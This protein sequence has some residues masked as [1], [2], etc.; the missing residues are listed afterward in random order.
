MGEKLSFE[1]AMAELGLGRDELLNLTASGELRGTHDGDEIWF[2]SEEVSALKRSRETEPTVILADREASP[3]DTGDESPIDLDS[4]STDETVLNI[5]GLLEDDAE[6]TTPVPGLGILEDELEIGSIGEDTVLDTD[7]LELDDDF[8]VGSDDDTV[9]AGGGE[10]FL[11]A[12]GTQ[13]MQMI[14]KRGSPAMTILLAATILVM[15]GP[16]A[17]VLNLIGAEGGV[18][19]QW[20]EGNI[21]FSSLGDM[22][23]SLLGMF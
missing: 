4:I 22:F 14:Q 21:V 19:P 8:D 2:K 11:A 9:A 5:E 3:F 18:Y 12:G 15:L 13:R 16:A 6:G 7:G 1:Q 23:Q 10:A 17:V 20:V